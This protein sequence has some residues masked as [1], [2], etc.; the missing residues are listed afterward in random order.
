MIKKIQIE[1]II[2]IVLL[3]NALLSY[4]VDLSIYNYFYN[5]NY[6]VSTSYL[7]GFF[8]RVTELGDSLWY[9]LII[10]LILIFSF[11]GKFL[12]I[13]S[14]KHYFILRN[15]S[16]FSFVYLSLVGIITQA[17]KHVIGRPRPNHADFEK[18]F[19]FNFFSTDASFH[20]FPSGHSSTIFAVALVMCS[21]VPRLRM[22]FLFFGFVV[23][24]SRVVVGA[25][26]VTD[27]IA[28]GLLALILYKVVLSIFESSLPNISVK[29][30]EIKNPSLFF[31]TNIVFLLAGILI[32]VGHDLD[33]FF[34]SFFYY[35]KSQFFLQS[36]DALS[37]IF[38]DIFLPFLVVYLFIFP[39]ITYFFPINQLYF[40]HRFLIKELLFVFL[41]GIITLGLV[42]N[43]L[44]KNMWGRTRPNDILQFGG[45][46]VFSPWYKFGGGCISN[47]SFVSGDASV[48][49]A[50]IL[51]YFITKK[52][53]YVHLSVICGLCLGLVRIVAG[54][55]FFSDI[56]FSQIV[57]TASIFASFL[58][59]KKISNA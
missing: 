4:K 17:L 5:L 11:V 40:G 8:I 32:T 23:A 55:H 10:V 14:L 22:F 52:I 48:G 33:I 51:F 18:G 35:G 19:D 42:V 46:D 13:T 50:L 29:E 25:H 59:Y 36:Y 9:F 57:V 6:G 15:F 26:F 45:N 3:A 39:T 41:A 56:I 28:G 37:I 20:S 53:I 24:L 12:K 47:C 16:I 44:L 31:K 27:V 7:K 2:L 54:G 58:I 30:F 21:L 43:I 38:R 49:F 34:S 1:L